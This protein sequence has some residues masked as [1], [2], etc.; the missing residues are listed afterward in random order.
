[1]MPLKNGGRDGLD[2]DTNPS[3]I[4]ARLNSD[5]GLYP[6]F[7]ELFANYAVNGDPHTAPEYY[8]APD[9]I[10]L[11]SAWRDAMEFFIIGH[12][13]GHVR[14]GHL[15]APRSS[16]SRGGYT[17]IAAN[18]DQE[19]AADRFGLNVTLACLAERHRNPA[20]TCAGVAMFL[21]GLGMVDQVV[22]EFFGRPYADEGSETHPPV[23]L[24]IDSLRVAMRDHLDE[25]ESH[26]A[27]TLASRVDGLFR[28]M[29]PPLREEI[30]QLLAEG[31]RLHTKWH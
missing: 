16:V 13:F 30:A 19:F 14:L 12:E 4:E 1:M 15:D 24:R 3:A 20:V 6:R 18:W 8:P 5:L 11:T 22:A 2:I 17:E 23:S 27:A 10:P 25:A 31:A 21:R 29:W 26:A 9:Y 28:T 7:A